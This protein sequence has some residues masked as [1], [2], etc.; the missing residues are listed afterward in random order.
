[1]LTLKTGKETLN[2]PLTNENSRLAQEIVNYINSEKENL[3]NASPEYQN[4][5]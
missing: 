2:Y 5:K 1:M 4:E 3:V